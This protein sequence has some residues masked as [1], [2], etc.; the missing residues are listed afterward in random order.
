MA[1]HRLSPC[2]ASRPTAERYR[3][4]A[5]EKSR[6]YF[7]E[8]GSPPSDCYRG[9]DPCVF[10]GFLEGIGIHERRNDPLLQESLTA[11]PFTRLRKSGKCSCILPFRRKPDRSKLPVSREVTTQSK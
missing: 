10:D 5:H 11:W 3:S 8:L 2:S 9:S 6:G 1:W 7:Q 4:R